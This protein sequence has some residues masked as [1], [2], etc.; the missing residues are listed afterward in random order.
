MKHKT[1]LVKYHPKLNIYAYTKSIIE[2]Y[3]LSGSKK[4]LKDKFIF[5]T[6]NERFSLDELKERFQ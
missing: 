2:G 6:H 4:K 3:F 5:L 1:Y